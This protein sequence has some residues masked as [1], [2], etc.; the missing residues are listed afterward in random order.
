MTLLLMQ[1]FAAA[2]TVGVLALILLWWTGR[3]WRRKHDE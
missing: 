1:N 3:P 2:V